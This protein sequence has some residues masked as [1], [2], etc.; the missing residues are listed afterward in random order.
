MATATAETDLTAPHRRHLTGLAVCAAVLAL[1]GVL[2]LAIGTQTVGL[3]TVWRA[4]TEYTDTGNEWIV[5]ELRIPR[6]VLGVV[7]GVA[8]GLAGALIQGI[9]RN[10]LADSQI[11]GIEA[12]AGLF[13]V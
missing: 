3:P 11:L 6:T 1:A 10:P 2:S 13:V 7:V 9:T 12:V 5:H 4:V 8:L